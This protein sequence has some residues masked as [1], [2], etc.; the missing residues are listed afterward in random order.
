ME[1]RLAWNSRQSLG[2][3][4]RG[5]WGQLDRSLGESI[6]PQAFQPELDLWDPHVDTEN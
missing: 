1:V 3:L 6:G 4:E 2:S 5:N